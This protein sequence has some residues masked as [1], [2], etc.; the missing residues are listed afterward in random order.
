[1]KCHIESSDVL[2]HLCHPKS[3]IV[4]HNIEVPDQILHLRWRRTQIESPE[5]SPSIFHINDIL[6]E[7]GKQTPAFL[8]RNHV[9]RFPKCSCSY[10]ISHKKSE[11]LSKVSPS[12]RKF[13]LLLLLWRNQAQADAFRQKHSF[14]VSIRS[15]PDVL[16]TTCFFCLSSP[17]QTTG[18]TLIPSPQSSW[19]VQQSLPGASADSDTSRPER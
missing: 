18:Q 5:T 12:D 3:S 13:P 14:P 2:Q 9:N 11:L 4:A 1:M 7:Y 17:V 10:P 16:H 19:Q 15:N 6:R 8:P